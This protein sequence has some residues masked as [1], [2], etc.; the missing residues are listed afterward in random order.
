MSS[1]ALMAIDE[2]ISYNIFNPI[3]SVF[4]LLFW[5]NFDTLNC[6]FNIG[7]PTSSGAK[8]DQMNEF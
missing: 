8:H 2:S 6:I 3:L 7:H 5:K 1:D 4:W